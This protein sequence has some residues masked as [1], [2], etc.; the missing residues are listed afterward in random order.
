MLSIEIFA[1]MTKHRMI[2]YHEKSGSECT[3]NQPAIKAIFCISV[4][5]LC[6]PGVSAGGDFAVDGT[7]PL[8][9]APG[10]SS[11]DCS[12]DTLNP[13]CPLWDGEHT[14]PDPFLVYELRR[15]LAAAVRETQGVSPLQGDP[16]ILS[17]PPPQGEFP[18]KGTVRVPVFLV[19]FSDAPHDPSQTVADVQ[20]KMFGDGNGGYP[21]ESL[22]NYYQRSSYNQLTITG[23]VYGWYRAAQPRSYYV[24]MGK[25]DGRKALINEILLAYNS[26]INFSNYDANGNGKIDALFIKWA[27][28]D[29]G[30]GSFWWASMS[31]VF[32][33]VTV[34]GVTPR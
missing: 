25:S 9:N 23:D 16:G 28:P 2:E 3:M 1:Y 33:S 6:L 4:L 21:Y 11:G 13:Y 26:Q 8:G 12:N 15:K 5:V 17:L 18:T 32:S 10:F 19:D 20:S 34:D 14:K 30:W 31:G 22:K 27:G 24:S 29:T 7:F